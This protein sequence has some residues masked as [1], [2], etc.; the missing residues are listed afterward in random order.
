[1]LFAFDRSSASQNCK[2]SANYRSAVPG[3][4]SFFKFPE[5]IAG[6]RV[7][8]ATL[9]KPQLGIGALTKGGEA[10]ARRVNERSRSA[11]SA[12]AAATHGLLETPTR[13]ASNCNVGATSDGYASV[14][15]DRKRR[16]R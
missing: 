13:P 14:P 4:K 10:S 2:T 16:D 5:E 9:G 11:A 3:I 15:D 12:D 7:V 1:M 6:V 8:Y